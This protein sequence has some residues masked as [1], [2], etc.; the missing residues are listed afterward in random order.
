MDKNR[1]IGKNNQL[2][3]RIPEELKFFK[4]M[5]MGFSCVMGRKTW[6]SLPKKPLPGRFNIILS[7]YPQ[8]TDLTQF[9]FVSNIY[10]AMSVALC[11]TPEKVFIIGGAKVY[12]EAL[13]NN[14]VD[15]IIVSKVKGDYEGDTYFP[16]IDQWSENLIEEHEAFSVYEYRI[17]KEI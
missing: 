6:D 8:P 4:K 10:D 7:H 12:E 9:A 16:I 13:K 2:P 3:W 17:I 11:K 15:S 14:L 1:L 5:T